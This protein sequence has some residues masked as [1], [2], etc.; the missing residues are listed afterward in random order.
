MER[1]FVLAPA[2]PEHLTGIMEIETLCFAEEAFS[3]RQ[4]AY[5]LSKA[6]GEFYVICHNQ[7]VA[8]YISMVSRSNASNLRIYSIAVHPGAR[9]HHLATALLDKSVEY[10]RSHQLY[11]ITLEVHTTNKAALALY[12]KSGFQIITV[13]PGYYHNGDA[14]Y[15]KKML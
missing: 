14:Y 2:M 1:E 15:M 12:T 5:L 7:Q 13:K 6:K 3:R 9:G 4:M 10:A 8:A 11:S